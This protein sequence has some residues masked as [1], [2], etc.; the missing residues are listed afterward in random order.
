M[1][2]TASLVILSLLFE[3]NKIAHYLD[4]VDG[5]LNAFYGLRGDFHGKEETKLQQYPLELKLAEIRLFYI[6]THR[7]PQIHNV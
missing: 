1:K 3:R 7:F 4:Y 2:W 5:V 6:Y